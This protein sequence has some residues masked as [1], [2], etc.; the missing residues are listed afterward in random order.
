MQQNIANDIL[1]IIL[2]GLII[3]A[4]VTTLV[5]IIMYIAQEL[6]ITWKHKPHGVC[7]VQAEGF[8]LGYYFYFRSRYETSK[9]MFLRQEKDWDDQLIVKEY[10]LNKEKEA[11]AA[12]YINNTYAKWLIYKGCFMFLFN[13]I[14]RNFKDAIR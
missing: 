9:I 8:F 7:P 3:T 12:G 2:I 11:Y 10:I 1:L 14:W 6:Q 5:G 13:R 4:V